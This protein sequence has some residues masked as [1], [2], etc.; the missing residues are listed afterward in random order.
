[1]TPR[2]TSGMLI[3]ALRRRAEADG[4]SATILSRG[5]EISGALIIAWADKGETQAMFERGLGPDDCYVWREAGPETGSQ[6][7]QFAQYLEKRRRFDPD[8][9]VVE[10]DGLGDPDWLQ[11]MTGID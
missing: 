5:D 9:W 6:W 2:I 1:M 4:G 8:I 3:G 10:I 7:P 11:A